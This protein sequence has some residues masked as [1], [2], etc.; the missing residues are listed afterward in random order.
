MEPPLHPTQTSRETARAEER[1]A[2][3]IQK[4]QGEKQAEEES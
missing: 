3:N 2:Q 1:E 4:D